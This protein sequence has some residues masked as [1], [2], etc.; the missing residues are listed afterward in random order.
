MKAF[1]S[2]KVILL[3][4]VAALV[5]GTSRPA[6]AASSDDA[7]ASA[8]QNAVYDQTAAVKDNPLFLRVTQEKNKRDPLLRMQAPLINMIKKVEP[9]VV[10][11]E[12]T[13]PSDPPKKTKPKKAVCTGFF[14]DSAKYL[15]RKS[16]VMTNAHCVDK[17][18]IGADIQVGLY[19]GN[20]NVPKMTTGIVLAYGSPE[21]GKDIAFVEL[22]D[23]SL[24]RPPLPLWTR[25]EVGEQVIAIGNP[26]GFL[27]SVSRGIIS[28]LDRTEAGSQFITA[29]QS[30]VA[31]NP[32]NSGGPL[33]NMWGSVVGINAMIAS[34]SGGFE[35]VSFSVPADDIIEAMKQ[36]ARTGNLKVGA[37][38]FA[39]TIDEE[40]QK[41]TVKSV[42]PDGPAAAAHMQPQDQIL[43]VDGVDIG[44]L[45]PRQAQKTF[46]THVKYLSPG[47]RTTIV[48]L[49]DGKEVSLQVTLG[50]A[51]P[52]QPERPE[53]APIPKR[54][55]AYV[56][57]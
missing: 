29:N 40:T 20:D 27:F 28:A 26:E 23:E 48:V 4:A 44:G 18:D 32:G 3:G 1:N 10:F 57:L 51:K 41:L 39:F 53:W 46:L 38:Q 33:F 34:Q 36:Y 7:F 47:E 55:S 21:T 22:K 52:P 56:M 25:L 15:D 35:G 13:I 5:L 9:S 16:I 43:R 45:T 17:L 37:M 49:R 2:R 31:V 6:R 19:D 24:N 50:E 42:A 12:I 11:L 14:A 30:D 54:P 8:V